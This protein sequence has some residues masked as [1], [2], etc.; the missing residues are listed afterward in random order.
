MNKLL[1]TLL[2]LIP[3]GCSRHTNTWIDGFISSEDVLICKKNVQGNSFFAAL[4]GNRIKIGYKIDITNRTRIPSAYVLKTKILDSNG[5]SI[6]RPDEPEIVYDEYLLFGER[7]YSQE[8]SYVSA[9]LEGVDVLRVEISYET[10][11]EAS[12]ALKAGEDG[13]LE[14]ILRCEIDIPED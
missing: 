10:Y 8:V 3:L 14:T 4:S 5:K 9:Y 1:M 11:R 12:G 7:T 2:I 6:G 13:N